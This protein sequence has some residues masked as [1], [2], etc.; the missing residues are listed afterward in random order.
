MLWEIFFT[1]A[2]LLFILTNFSYS[3]T[4]ST[5]AGSGVSGFN[6]GTPLSAEFTQIFGAVVDD[7]GNIYIA[8]CSN[9]RIRKIDHTTGF[10]S[11]YAGYGVAGD[12]DGN[13]LTAQICAPTSITID[14]K[15]NIY[16]GEDYNSSYTFGNKIK[17]ITTAGQV[18]TV[19]GN[20]AT[21]LVDGQGFNAEF[22]I[23]RGICADS[24]GN[25]YVADRNNHA[26]RKVDTNGYVS[27]IAGNGTAG[28]ANGLG[29]NASFNNPV[30]ICVDK[31]GNLYVA[32]MKNNL[33]RKI[34]SNGTVSTFAGTGYAG[35]VNGTAL[36]SEFNLPINIVVTSK[37]EFYV[38]EGTN[39]TIRK[40]SNTGMVTTFTG[41]GTSGYLDGDLLTAMFNDPGTLALNHNE[42]IMI[43]GDILNYRIRKINLRSNDL[44]NNYV[45]G[46]Q[47]NCYPNPASE[48]LHIDFNAE[49]QNNISYSLYDMLGKEVYHTEMLKMS[50]YINKSI[51]LSELKDGLYVLLV[52]TDN[53]N[54]SQKIIVRK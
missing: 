40:I 10:V 15:G 17:K 46:F 8:D 54:F 19:A 43:I 2:S 41:T 47:Y 48:I 36:S 16:F 18:I 5:I 12:I 1:Y 4:V 6:D 9:N 25:I 32:D 3:Q 26:I 30:G 7:T 39:C 21:G 50:G 28:S 14:H 33:I 27:T 35:L 38:G 37:L 20:G 49:S 24:I 13:R 31:Y 52:K 34:T 22:N 44:V 45:C 11:T 29:T 53:E 23:P 42:T 51:D